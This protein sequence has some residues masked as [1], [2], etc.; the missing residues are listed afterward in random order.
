MVCMTY[1]TLQQLGASMCDT[2]TFE[3]CDT[4]TLECVVP[5]FMY[6]GLS[7]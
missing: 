1:E 7:L 2:W 4:W 5:Y 6:S 3:L